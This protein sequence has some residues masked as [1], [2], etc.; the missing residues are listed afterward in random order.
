MNDRIV[1]QEAVHYVRDTGLSIWEILRLLG[2]GRTETELASTF[3]QLRHED[4]L[5]VYRAA[6]SVGTD[7]GGQYMRQLTAE[8]ERVMRVIKLEQ[9]KRR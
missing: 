8:L 3:P 1:I 2:E 4:F 6:T 9:E 5:A 7:I